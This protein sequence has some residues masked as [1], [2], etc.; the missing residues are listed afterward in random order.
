[1]GLVHD[2][3]A[4]PSIEIL[5]LHLGPG[6]KHKLGYR[7]TV[8]SLLPEPYTKCTDEIPH[9]MKAVLANY[10]NG[11]YDYLRDLCF[12]VAVQLAMYAFF[13]LNLIIVFIRVQF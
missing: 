8:S 5:G 6:R 4:I 9:S 10:P 2:N 13:I 7:K 11:N 1:M 3:R 12:N